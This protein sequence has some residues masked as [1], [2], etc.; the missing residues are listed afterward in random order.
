MDLV[1]MNEMIS[2]ENDEMDSKSIADYIA[3]FKRRHK[4]IK[5]VISIFCF[6]GLLATILWP[7][8]Y[9]ST[10]VILI[11]SQ[12]VPPDL[13]RSTITSY[14]I[15]RIEEIKQRI[16][17]T[18]N[19]ISIAQ[20]FE[21]YTEGEFK[22]YTRTEISKKF[23]DNLIVEPISADVIDPRSGNPT[24]AVIAFKLSFDGKDPQKVY[25][26]SNEL[27]TLYLN[28]NLR[29]R[30]EQSNSTSNFLSDEIKSINDQ[31]KEQEEK[32]AK[33]KEENQGSLPELN[34]YNMSIVDRSQQ[35]LIEINTRLQQLDSRK[36][37]LESQLAQLNPS[38]PTILSDGKAVLSDSDRL[39]ALQ[40][41]YRHKSAIY[42]SDHPDIIR[43]NR[44]IESLQ[45]LLGI[46]GSEKDIAKQLQTAQEQLAQAKGTYT[47][48]H[49]EIR[50]LTEQVEYLKSEL[51]TG[52]GKPVELVPDNPSYVLLDTQLKAV[53]S[54]IASLSPKLNELRS[55]IAHHEQLLSKAPAVERDYQ[56]LLRDYDN[57][58]LKYREIS[59]KQMHADL[60]KNLEVE[61]KGERFTLIQP[62]E[63]PEEPVSINR[64]VIAF[65]FFFL[66]IVAG[67]VGGILAEKIDSKIYG[68]K[69][70]EA[71]IG[72]T[73]LVSVPYYVEPIDKSLQK[74]QQLTI[75]SLI[76][77]S[78][79]LL[80]A[81]FHF[82]IKPLD[83]TWYLVLHKLGLH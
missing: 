26:V 27:I 79:V 33:F 68:E 19:I 39:K 45:K 22:R 18:S 36:I 82:F 62:P 32:L 10:A 65:L 34:N 20:R 72:M 5:R 66:A 8:T 69:S 58:R 42:S 48:D 17:T 30:T 12:D 38:A 52:S 81:A 4:I 47:S 67:L 21:L 16:M 71:I 3:V 70:I 49:P 25:K 40:S 24:K 75:I 50:K 57:T 73:A 51:A 78:F 2:F 6:I 1:K 83:V 60:G 7:A 54:E 9:R 44:E 64:F 63:I 41:E 14:A 11:E 13:I 61:R 28:E 29:G 55:V 23:R 31:L 80:L 53:D 35:N 74:K 43:L 15:Q 76:V 37:E 77:L 46:A 59:E 56:T